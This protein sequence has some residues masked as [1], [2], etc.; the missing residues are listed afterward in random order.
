MI[1]PYMMVG[2]VSRV[3]LATNLGSRDSCISRHVKLGLTLVGCSTSQ[4]LS[5][6]RRGRRY[7]PRIRRTFESR[8]REH[9]IVYLNAH[10]EV[11]DFAF[12]VF[13]PVA[14]D[15]EFH[16]LLEAVYIL[17][18]AVQRLLRPLLTA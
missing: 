9:R 12:E 18:V 6:V 3:R 1:P 15:D 5:R 14:F 4:P 11:R 17:V 7:T 10:L 16:R 2:T 13:F 8:F